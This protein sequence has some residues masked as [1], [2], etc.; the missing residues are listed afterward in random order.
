MVDVPRNGFVAE[1][2]TFIESS[3]VEDD[4]VDVPYTTVPASVTATLEI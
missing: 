4:T 2:I 1:D 3:L